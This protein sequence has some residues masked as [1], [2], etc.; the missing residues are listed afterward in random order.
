MIKS[1]YEKFIINT[2]FFT[3]LNYYF[4][5]QKVFLKTKYIFDL[6]YKKFINSNSI[7]IPIYYLHT[8]KLLN[9][10]LIRFIIDSKIYFNNFTININIQ[11]KD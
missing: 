8:K 4:L 10:F 6:F 11:I 7:I 5:A 9:L 3:I 1:F 2:I